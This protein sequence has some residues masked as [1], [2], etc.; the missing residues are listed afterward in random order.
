MIPVSP[1]HIPK[2]IHQMW[3]DRVIF[4]NDTPPNKYPKYR[5]YT[6]GWKDKNPDFQYV[7]WNRRKIED[8]WNHPKLAQWKPFV[9]QMSKHIEKCDFTRYAILYLHGGFY[10]DLDFI[11]LKHIGPLIQNREFLW[12]YEPEVHKKPLDGGRTRVFNGVLASRPDHWI[13][14][15]LMTYIQ[16]IY[17]PNHEVMFNTGPIRLSAFVQKYQIGVKYPNYFVDKCLIIPLDSTRQVCTECPR[18]SLNNAYCYTFWN[19]GSGWAG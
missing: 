10:C 5:Q 7:F 18:D 2:I 16:E 9:N 11:C 14:P 1:L 19:E 3:F 17:R 12:T 4:D 6:Q 15:L 8:L 13:W